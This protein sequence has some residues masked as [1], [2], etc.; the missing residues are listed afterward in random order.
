M[1][2][3][4][5][6]IIT[7][8]RISRVFEVNDFFKEACRFKIVNHCEF[9]FRENRQNRHKS[10]I[11]INFPQLFQMFHSFVHANTLCLKLFPSYKSS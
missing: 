1:V 5:I 8:S 4:K 11:L 10:T 3:I 7:M 9:K 2:Q 6:G